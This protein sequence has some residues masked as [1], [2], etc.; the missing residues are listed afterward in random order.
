LHQAKDEAST[1]SVY[2]ISTPPLPA[3]RLSAA[4]CHL[5]TSF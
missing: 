5:T 4:I 1:L 2:L 3:S